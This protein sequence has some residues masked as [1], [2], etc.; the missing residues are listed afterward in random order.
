MSE[1]SNVEIRSVDLSLVWQMRRD[2]MYPEFDIEGVKLELDQEGQHLGLYVDAELISVI[3][4]FI[5]KGELQ[6]RKFCTLDNHQGKGYGSQLLQ[7]VFEIA[8]QQVH[9]NKVWC[10]ARVSALGFYER[11]G[12]K[13]TDHTYNKDGHDFVIMQSVSF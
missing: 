11:F 7:H 3:S 10:N 6:F 1:K 8:K 9:V 4:L 2:I 12:M 13:T 5:E